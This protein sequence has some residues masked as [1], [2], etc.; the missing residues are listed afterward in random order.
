MQFYEGALKV[1][2]VERTIYIMLPI[3]NNSHQFIFIIRF[4]VYWHEHY[5]V[6]KSDW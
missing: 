3:S 6:Y 4:C 1:V 5:S 2:H